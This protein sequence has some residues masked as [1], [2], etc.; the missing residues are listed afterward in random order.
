MWLDVC[1]L[2]S[3]KLRN[4]RRTTVHIKNRQDFS[5]RRRNVKE[6]LE[7]AYQRIEQ[8]YKEIQFLNNQ[9]KDLETYIRSQNGAGK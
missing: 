3:A 9:L 5:S 7:V 4:Q 1:N 6:E 8:L 2:G